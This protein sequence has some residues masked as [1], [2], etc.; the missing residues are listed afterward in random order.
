VADQTWE[1]KGRARLHDDST[2][3]ENEAD[4]GFRVGNTN[5]GWQAHGDTYA[6]GRTLYSGYRRL[7]AGVNG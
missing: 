3:A 1:K 2:P 5:T 7:R 4:L 6:N